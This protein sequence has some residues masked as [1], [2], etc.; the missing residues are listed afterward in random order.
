MDLREVGPGP[1]GQEVCW[2]G[3]RESPWSETHSLGWPSWG[4]WVGPPFTP[5][6]QKGRAPDGAVAQSGQQTT[7]TAPSLSVRKDVFVGVTDDSP[8]ASGGCHPGSAV[9]LSGLRALQSTSE[10]IGCNQGPSDLGSVFPR[11]SLPLKAVSSRSGT[12][13]SWAQL[14]I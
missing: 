3:Q 11:G 5:A 2:E 14:S 12:S 8:Q 6:R 7:A 1:E 13:L 4:V 9:R 10:H